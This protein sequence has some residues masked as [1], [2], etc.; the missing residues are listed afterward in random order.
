[1]V[2]VLDRHGKPLDPC[3]EKR[4]RLLLDRGRARIHRL[5]PVFT[6]RLVDRLVEDS[7]IHNLDLGIDPG[8]AHSGLALSMKTENGEH[9][10][11]LF[12]LNHR[13]L[14]IKEEM[15]TRSQARRSRRSRKSRY[16]EERSDNRTREE[17]WLPPSIAH[18]VFSLK[19]FVAK[20]SKS[21]NI[22]SVTCET[23]KFDT[24]KMQNPEISGTEYQRGE[25]SGW[26]VREYLLAKFGY[27]CAYC[28]KSDVPL[29]I[30][31]VEPKARHGSDRVSNLVIACRACN[32][33]KGDQPVGRFVKDAEKLKQIREQMKEP[34]RDAAALNSTRWRIYEEL[35][36][37]GAPVS[38][39]YG[40]QTKFNRQ[41]FGI[42]KTHALDA[43]Y[44]G[45]TRY[46]SG[47]RMPVMAVT[48]MG[49][50]RRFRTLLDEYGFPRK[51]TDCLTRKKMHY[52]FQTGDLVRADKPLKSKHGGR[53]FGRIAIRERPSFHMKTSKG[54]EF[55]IHP[56]YLRLL[57][58]NDGYAYALV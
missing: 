40:S 41:K 49:R 37:F 11:A 35:K 22:G 30:D 16:R 23:A 26:E 31:H 43:L 50:G 17:G 20:L 6:I 53:H 38:I 10:V 56:K 13:G 47:W 51:K 42:P 27:K 18:R 9:A 7:V 4:A 52:G 12:Q 57:Q 33:A 2:A 19:R 14:R 48:C 45:K 55:D 54:V 21:F 36:S 1:M 15:N 34:L 39:C 5:Y 58:R 28:G 3:T 8:S 44:T 29:T 32:Q 25:L 46:V 24:Q